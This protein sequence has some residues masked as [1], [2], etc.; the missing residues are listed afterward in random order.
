MAHFIKCDVKDCDATASVDPR[1]QRVPR[2]WITIYM[3]PS[4]IELRKFAELYR[5]RHGGPLT[6]SL[7]ECITRSVVMCEKHELPA[8][9]DED[10]E[11]QVDQQLPPPLPPAEY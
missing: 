7:L 2:G 4:E 6:L 8:F 11:Q 3:S 10:L 5:E 9:D 1:N